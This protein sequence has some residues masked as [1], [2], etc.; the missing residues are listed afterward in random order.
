MV[1]RWCG[2]SRGG[3]QPIAIGAVWALVASFLALDELGSGGPARPAAAKRAVSV[4]ISVGVAESD[5]TGA[6]PH[7]VL[8]AAEH[9]LDHVQQAGPVAVSA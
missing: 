2:S 7:K 6:D 1:W 8:R 5:G 9:A 3:R 4:T